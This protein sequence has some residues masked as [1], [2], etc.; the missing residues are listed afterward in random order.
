MSR[1]P[2]IGST[3]YVT[4]SLAKGWADSVGGLDFV[5]AKI[6]NGQK[7]LF[8]EWEPVAMAA[9]AHSVPFH[10]WGWVYARDTEEA[11]REGRAAGNQAK[12]IGVKA[13]WVNAE[14]HWLGL[15][16]EPAVEDPI[17]AMATYVSTFRSVAPGIDLIYN[18]MTG[19]MSYQIRDQEVELVRLFD[20]YGP[21]VY[22]TSRE[23]QAKK[24]VRG[25]DMANQ[26]GRP[27]VPMIGSGRL[28]DA[29]TKYWGYFLGKG[30]EPGIA[31]LQKS[32][33]AEW[34]T[35]WI[36]PQGGDR[37]YAANVEN[38][39]ILEMKELVQA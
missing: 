31:E 24:W 35:C 36:A 19:W 8:G 26:A 6:I 14:K 34:I 25:Y 1:K 12:A 15:G 20:A 10:G 16:N 32:H 21:M 5:S 22:A 23:T 29:G 2:A 37:L 27:Y 13:F 33:P 9:Q 30:M 17:G 7:L 38:P 4:S 28:N 11:E 18:S 39:S 3:F